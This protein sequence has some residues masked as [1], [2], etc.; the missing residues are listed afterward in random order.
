MLDRP[1]LSGPAGAGL[2][3]VGDEQDAVL[4]A[5]LPEALEETVLGND[6]AALALDRFDHDGRDLVGGHEPLEQDLVEPAEVLNLAERRVVDAGQ[7]R[8]ESSVVLRLRRR[9]RHRTVGP[10]MK[11]A[12][13]PDDVRPAGEMASELHRGFHDLGAGVA[14]VRPELAGHR[15]DVR[16]RLGR[17]GVDRQVEV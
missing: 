6:V 2:D 3:L 8:V 17:L 1:H 5:H 10:A 12:Q 7:E 14:E 16:D 9:E 13:E 4:R 11:A 15:G